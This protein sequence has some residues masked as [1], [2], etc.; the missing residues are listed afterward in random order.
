MIE[1]INKKGASVWL[2]EI[3]AGIVS[4][5]VPDIN[6]NL[7]DVALGYKDMK[8]YLGDGPCSGKIPGRFANRIAGGKFFLEG[9]KYDLP[10]N[11]GP[12]HL[13]G[14]PE[15]FSNKVW[16]IVPRDKWGFEPDE[17]ES[18]TVFSL[19]SSAGDS[20]YP[21]KLEVKAIYHWKDSNI[22]SL[23]I[24]ATTDSTTIINLTNHT[25]WNLAGED[26]GSILDHEL[27]LNASNYLPTDDTLIPTGEIAPVAGTPMNF[28]NPKELGRDIKADF[29]ALLFGKGYDNCWVVD[30]WQPVNEKN[31]DGTSIKTGKMCHIGTLS[32][33]KSGRIMKIYSTQPGVQVYTG[34]WLAGSPI[35]KSGRSYNDYDG[36]AIE[37]QG[38]PDSP[39]K[40]QFPSPILYKGDIYRHLIEFRFT[41]ATI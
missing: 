18:V 28:T 41:N 36:V 26:S 17:D 22:L 25:Y 13:H 23:E 39:N 38:F 32:D 4:V 5:I 27:M 3:G 8:S 10:I 11:N 1:L 2:N 6:G 15:G 19:E 14:G 24:T 29:D 7:A 21:G 12:N 30:G 31:D 9:K 34:N 33:K 16:S 40:P 37:C 35:S 20:G